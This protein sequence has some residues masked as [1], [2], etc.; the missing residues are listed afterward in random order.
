MCKK[1]FLFESVTALNLVLETMSKGYFKLYYYRKAQ[2]AAKNLFTFKFAFIVKIKDN[3]KL[4]IYKPILL[5]Y[6]LTIY[7]CLIIL[8]YKNHL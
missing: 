3:L 2:R 8:L 6:K 5:I 1:M 4:F 7:K